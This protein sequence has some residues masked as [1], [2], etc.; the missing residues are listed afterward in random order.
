MKFF[1]VRPSEIYGKFSFN[2]KSDQFGRERA[3]TPHRKDVIPPDKVEKNAEVMAED[4][5]RNRV[6]DQ[7]AKTF[8]R[9]VGHKFNVSTR[10]LSVIHLSCLVSGRFCLCDPIFVGK[11]HLLALFSKS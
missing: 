6:F 4:T 8:S 1:P 2:R 7:P 3:G 5:R 11:L 9:K 10:F